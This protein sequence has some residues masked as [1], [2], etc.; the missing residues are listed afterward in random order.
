MDGPIRGPAS[1]F[2]S[3]C[4]HRPLG[5]R[6]AAHPPAAAAASDS[7]DPQPISH[8]LPR[9]SGRWSSDRPSHP[10]PSIAAR[11][12]QRT[13][14]SGP[15]R[16]PSAAAGWLKLGIHSPAARAFGR[17]GTAPAT[18][19]RPRPAAHL[20]RGGTHSVTQSSCQHDE[21]DQQDQSDDEPRQKQ[22]HQHAQADHHPR[23]PRPSGNVRVAPPA[24][25]SAM[26]PN[27]PSC[28][29][30]ASCSRIQRGN[31]SSSMAT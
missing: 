7:R 29:A 11:T 15:E 10:A 17:A 31:E 12:G 25:M 24:G 19:R 8:Q 18:P 13:T 3:E 22:E 9:P 28:P 20:P 27:Q 21:D 16:P 30:R 14:P 23:S 2:R 1:R 4:R 5:R 6:P 26:S